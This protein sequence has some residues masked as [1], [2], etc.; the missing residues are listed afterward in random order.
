MKFLILNIAS[1]V[2]MSCSHPSIAKMP[3]WINDPM[4]ACSDERELCAVGEGPGRMAAEANARKSLATIFKSKVEGSTSA[5]TTSESTQDS[6]GVVSGTVREDVDVH[7]KETTEALLEGVK[8]S[9]KHE[10]TDSFFALAVLNKREAAEHLAAKMDQIDDEIK[11]QYNDGRR[12]AIG[13]ALRSMKARDELDIRYHFLMGKTY[14]KRISKSK[15]QARKKELRQQNTTLQLLTDEIS[16]KKH[17]SKLLSTLFSGIDYKLVKGEASYKV[18]AKLVSEKEFLKVEG[19]EKHKFILTLSA[20]NSSGTKIGQI[21]HSV[22]Q[23]GRDFQQS[24]DRAFPKIKN[25]LQDHI[26]DLNID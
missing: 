15:L 19:F 17:L 18:Q 4:S 2:L 6:E 12:A 10:G 8:I 7:V 16:K 5:A 25:Y 13:R 1:L 21:E 14:R 23:V 9:K 20:F 22:S 24:Y 11:K 3:D 26:V